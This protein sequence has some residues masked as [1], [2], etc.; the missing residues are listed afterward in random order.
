MVV[1]EQPFLQRSSRMKKEERHLAV[2]GARHCRT[3]VNMC[4]AANLMYRFRKRTTRGLPVDIQWTSR[5]MKHP[6]KARSF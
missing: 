6:K 3:P 2:G 4:S 5:F 1:T